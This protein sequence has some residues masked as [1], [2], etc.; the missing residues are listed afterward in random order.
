MP[1]CRVIRAK[2][3]QRRTPGGC[4]R[5]APGA[6]YLGRPEV[7]RQELPK[8]IPRKK[9]H[10][11]TACGGAVSASDQP[12]KAARPAVTLAHKCSAGGAALRPR[13]DVRGDMASR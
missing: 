10:D 5:V 1:E 9:S 13:R 3:K 11:L 6:G 2:R 8:C 4:S 12:S 7:I